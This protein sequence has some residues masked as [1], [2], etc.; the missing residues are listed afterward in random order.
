[1]KRISSTFGCETYLQAS[2]SSIASKT[3]CWFESSQDFNAQWLPYGNRH[4]WQKAFDDEIGCRTELWIIRKGS[5]WKK[6][7]HTHTH[8][9]AKDPKSVPETL[10]SAR[11]PGRATWYRPHFPDHNNGQHADLWANKMMM[12]T[13][14]KMGR[15]LEAR[16]E[17]R[18]ASHRRKHLR[19]L[20]PW[21]Q[22]SSGNNTYKLT[23]TEL[24]G[25]QGNHL[26]TIWRVI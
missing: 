10:G 20:L 25:L 15:D 14:R 7:T 26:Y 9:H 3:T 21:S 17:H 22:A 13:L 8:T 16:M 6:K 23:S 19:C 2:F 18:W 12:F 5:W 11:V 24:L 1:M 4:L